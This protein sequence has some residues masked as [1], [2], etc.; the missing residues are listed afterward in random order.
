MDPVFIS[1]IQLICNV[2]CKN[3]DRKYIRVHVVR[4]ELFDFLFN[5]VQIIIK[6]MLKF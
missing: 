3:V 1:T 5:W 6:I 4:I 2:L